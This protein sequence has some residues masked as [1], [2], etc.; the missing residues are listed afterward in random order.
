MTHFTDKLSA[1]LNSSLKTE[2]RYECSAPGKHFTPAPAPSPSKTR[3]TGCHDDLQCS[4][5]IISAAIRALTAHFR[6]F[7]LSP[8]PCHSHPCTRTAHA[9]AQGACDGG[10]RDLPAP[11]PCRSPTLSKGKDT[12]SEQMSK[13]EAYASL[14]NVVF[15]S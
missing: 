7:L 8:V 1:R 4:A 3:Q 2:M 5:L 9:S 10:A 14:V 12:N 15:K 6:P 11:F 13:M